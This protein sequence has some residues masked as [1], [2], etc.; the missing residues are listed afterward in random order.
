MGG[1]YNFRGQYI[2]QNWPEHELA[3]KP[4]INLLEIWAAQEAVA[5]LVAPGGRVKLHV[6][7][8]TAVVYIKNQVGTNSFSLSDEAVMLWE[9]AINRN[10]HVLTP[11]WISTQP[12]RTVGQTSCPGTT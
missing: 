8:M 4:H 11:H 6:E 7:N 5:L 10:I 9:D 12:V 3:T 2:Q 1:A